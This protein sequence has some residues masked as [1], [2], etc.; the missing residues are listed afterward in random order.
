ML[1]PD[2]NQE[3]RRAG[4]VEKIVE[5]KDFFIRSLI[6]H[7]HSLYFSPFIYSIPLSQLIAGMLP[8]IVWRQGH[9]L[10]INPKPIT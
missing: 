1:E 8:G 10:G 3:S 9:G 6:L 4:E 5:G 2:R 7:L